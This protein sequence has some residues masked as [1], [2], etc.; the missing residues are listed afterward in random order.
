M[1]EQGIEPVTEVVR[2]DVP[3]VALALAKMPVAIQEMALQVVRAQTQ[4]IEQ[5][6]EVIALLTKEAE[7][8]EKTADELKAEHKHPER[9]TGLRATARHK[10]NEIE[11]ARKAIQAFMV[12]AIPIPYLDSDKFATWNIEKL[13]YEALRFI[14]DHGIQYVFDEFGI[15]APS[16]MIY[17][18]WL[19]RE[20]LSDN[21]IRETHVLGRAVGD[22]HI[23]FAGR[24]PLL[25]GRITIGRKAHWFLLMGWGLPIEN[26]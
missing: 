22:S 2:T 11:Q 8:N 26:P 15:V 24:D 5:L 10:R 14:R 19:V 20:Q 9:V 3:S 4:R 7:F 21:R 23:L 6:E 16:N 1:T 25:I 13:P 12:G 18:Q 17:H